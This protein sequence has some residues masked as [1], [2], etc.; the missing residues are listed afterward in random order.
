MHWCG[1][2]SSALVRADARPFAPF[3]LALA[4]A[5]PSARSS[6]TAALAEH[7]GEREPQ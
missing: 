7:V 4:G 3:A 5:R 6:P 1:Q 2:M